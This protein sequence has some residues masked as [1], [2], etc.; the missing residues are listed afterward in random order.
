[1]DHRDY[2]VVNIPDNVVEVPKPWSEGISQRGNLLGQEKNHPF[3]LFEGRARS[4][5]DLGVT[6]YLPEP[7]RM[8]VLPI[9]P[10]NCLLRLPIFRFSSRFLL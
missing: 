7:P 4:E 10:L 1:M 6:S 8:V 5:V 9:W 3:M 2:W